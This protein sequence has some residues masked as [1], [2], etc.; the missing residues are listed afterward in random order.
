VEPAAALGRVPPRWREYVE[1]TY[2]TGVDVGQKNDPSCLAVIE[3][4]QLYVPDGRYSNEPIEHGEPEYWLRYAQRLP[5]NM[6][7]PAQGFWIAQK[8]LSR[9]ELADAWMLVDITGVGRAAVDA[10]R[11]DLPNIK[12]VMLTAGNAVERRGR[13]LHISKSILIQEMQAV[14]HYGKLKIPN[15]IPERDVIARECADF[16]IHYTATGA[17]QWNARSGSHD[18]TVIAIALALYGAQHLAAAG[19][20]LTETEGF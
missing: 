8:V 17:L 14:L 9:A 13:D 7:Y 5:L 3:R 11:A 20:V 10:W 12:G 18:D 2:A 15:S 1:S 4:R 6:P 16:E 19:P